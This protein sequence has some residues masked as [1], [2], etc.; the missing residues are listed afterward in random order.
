ML[1]I[2]IGIGMLMV[3]NRGEIT[4]SLE[5]VYM[6]EIYTTYHLFKGLG[7]NYSTVKNT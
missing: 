7:Q 5:T 6:L 3:P 2:R 4:Y 1:V